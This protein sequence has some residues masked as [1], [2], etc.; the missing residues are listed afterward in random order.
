MNSIKRSR[1]QQRGKPAVGQPAASPQD[2]GQKRNKNNRSQDS[3]KTM[4]INKNKEI[5]FVFIKPSRQ[6][7]KPGQCQDD[8]LAGRQ[9]GW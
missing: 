9:G 2:A 3:N 5:G 8:E 6:G 4:F 7:A 1:P